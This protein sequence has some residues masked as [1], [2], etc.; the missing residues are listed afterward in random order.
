MDVGRVLNV[1][2]MGSYRSLHSFKMVLVGLRMDLTDAESLDSG[3][4]GFSQRFRGI[5]LPVF[6]C[7]DG[8][9]LLRIGWSR[10]PQVSQARLWSLKADNVSHDK[11]MSP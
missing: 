11:V 10:P 4:F 9:D 8:M 1:Y 3:R 5:G 7:D 6:R 2:K